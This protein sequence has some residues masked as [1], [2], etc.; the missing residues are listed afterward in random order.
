MDTETIRYTVNT[1][2]VSSAVLSIEELVRQRV[3]STT[4]VAV[5]VDAE[6][7][8]RSAWSR[9]LAEGDTVDILTAV[10]GG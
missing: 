9:P 6:V 2:T 1:E 10:Q 5:A 8:P 3:G 4:G 7:L